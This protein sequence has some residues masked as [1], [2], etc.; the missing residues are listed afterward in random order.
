MKIHVEG[1]LNWDQ[2]DE[3]NPPKWLY[4]IIYFNYTVYDIQYVSMSIE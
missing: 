1:N 4:W 2:I 3:Y